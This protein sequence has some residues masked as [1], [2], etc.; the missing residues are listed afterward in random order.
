MP[1]ILILYFITATNLICVYFYLLKHIYEK[2]LRKKLYFK[3]ENS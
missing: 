2:Y 3:H 1:F